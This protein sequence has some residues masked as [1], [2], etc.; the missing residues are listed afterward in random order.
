MEQGGLSD[1]GG[2]HD[3][4]PLPLEKS[5]ID[6]SQDF[7]LFGPVPISLEEL[8]DLHEIPHTITSLAFSTASRERSSFIRARRSREIS[9]KTRRRAGKRWRRSVEVFLGQF[10]QFRGPRRFRMGHSGAV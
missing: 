7:H 8:L 9:F 3:R 5:E 4:R 10:E 1:T 6:P 2:T